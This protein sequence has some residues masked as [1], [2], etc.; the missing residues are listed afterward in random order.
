MRQLMRSEH[1]AIQQPL[2]REDR[3]QM[4]VNAW[5]GRP[6][7]GIDFSSYFIHHAVARQNSIG[8]PCVQS[9]SFPFVAFKG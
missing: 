2:S 4:I 6:L 7:A 9:S 8:V 3:T 1:P 5:I